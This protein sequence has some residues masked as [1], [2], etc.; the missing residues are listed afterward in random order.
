MFD[1]SIGLP[2]SKQITRLLSSYK[3]PNSFFISC[4]LFFHSFNIKATV[5]GIQTVLDL[6]FIFNDFNT[7][8]V[9][10]SLFT[11]E[12]NCLYISSL[13][14][15]PIIDLSIR[16]YCLSTTNLVLSFSKSSSSIWILFQ[17]RPNISDILNEHEKAKLIHKYK[18]WSSHISKACWISHAVH[19]S[20]SFDS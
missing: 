10:Q 20:L 7:I 19:I 18:I 1:F 2:F 15:I 6:P 16:T 3:L 13:V 12:S 8:T 5:R 4:C 14:K 9:L 11:C 17:V